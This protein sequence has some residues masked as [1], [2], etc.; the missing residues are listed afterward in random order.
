[1]DD[2]IAEIAVAEKQIDTE[3]LKQY[4]DF[5]KNLCKLLQKEPIIDNETRQQLEQ[6]KDKYSQMEELSQEQ[7]EELINKARTQFNEIVDQVVFKNNEHD[8]DILPEQ[9]NNL[10]GVIYRCDPQ[11]TIKRVERCLNSTPGVN[12][13]P[14]DKQYP[15][16]Y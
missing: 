15:S 9:F 12:L 4:F 2:N 11:E 16:D 13:P 1:M 3:Q 5:G 14:K 10:M 8:K 6:A 7:K